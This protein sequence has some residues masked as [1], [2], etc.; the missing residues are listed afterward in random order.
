MEAKNRLSELIRLA[1]AGHEV[2]I[3]NRGRPVVRLVATQARVASNASPGSAGGL[4]DW[5]KNNSPPRHCRRS[6]KDI[7]A[8]IRE[9]RAAWD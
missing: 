4:L 1:E 6:H 8:G 7:Q 9:E 2:V 3:A 5:L